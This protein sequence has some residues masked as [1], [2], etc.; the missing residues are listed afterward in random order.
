MHVAIDL[1][2]A[3]ARGMEMTGAGRYALETARSLQGRETRMAVLTLLQPARLARM[4]V[5]ER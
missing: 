4:G 3:D 2:I 5:V 1:R